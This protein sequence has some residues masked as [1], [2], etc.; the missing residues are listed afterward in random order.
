MTGSG[1]EC[2]HQGKEPFMNDQSGEP[3]AVNSE[4]ESPAR[5]NHESEPRS[6]LSQP[7]SREELPESRTRGILRDAIHKVMEEIEHHERE[8]R[9]HL[10]QAEA[11]RKDLHESL[12][13]LLEQG[14][15]KQV[16]GS[17]ASRVAK[18]AEAENQETPGEKPAPRRRRGR[19]RKR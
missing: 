11:L 1:P 4:V 6:G 15:I 14:K 13:F 16:A 7:G 12:A 18:A 19:P 5:Y 9:D 2:L 3:V 17:E 10:K 8:A